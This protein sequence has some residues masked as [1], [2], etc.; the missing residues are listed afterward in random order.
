MPISPSLVVSELDRR[1]RRLDRCVFTIDKNAFAAANEQSCTQSNWE[2][3]ADAVIRTRIDFAFGSMSRTRLDDAVGLGDVY[4]DQ[5]ASRIA[6]PSFLLLADPCKRRQTSGIWLHGVNYCWMVLFLLL[7]GESWKG[8]FEVHIG[9][10]IVNQG[11]RAAP[12][13]FRLPISIAWRRAGSSRSESPAHVH[14]GGTKS[15]VL[16]LRLLA[17]CSSHDT[18][19]RSKQP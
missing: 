3:F 10:R 14:C 2:R 8:V 19:S 15:T 17:S 13:R 1:K 4:I 18:S 12:P 5:H 7:L 6:H 11:E 16:F 9:L